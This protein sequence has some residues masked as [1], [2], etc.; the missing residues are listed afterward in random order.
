VADSARAAQIARVLHTIGVERALVVHGDGVDELPLDGSGIMYDVSAGG[1]REARVDGAT[2]GLSRAGRE[3][4]RGGDA[5]TNA[6]I[7]EAV[8]SGESGARRD[9]VLLNA[10]AAVLAGGR[11]SDLAQGVQI[12]AAAIDDGRAT[13]LLARLR[14]GRAVPA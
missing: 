12:A 14:A 11:S 13:D 6:T 3:S 2:V 9:V 4:L 1:V 10:G 5:A 7:I 8:L